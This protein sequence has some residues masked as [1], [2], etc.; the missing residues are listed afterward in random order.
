MAKR[1]T[2]RV[3]GGVVILPDDAALADG[4]DVV[5]EPIES[6]SLSSTKGST[7]SLLA[8]KARWAGSSDEII[9]LLDEVQQLRENDAAME[10]D[11]DSRAPRS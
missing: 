6:G 11:R 5:V 4:T 3:R 9:A 2:G 7:Q 10:R 1:F 8:C